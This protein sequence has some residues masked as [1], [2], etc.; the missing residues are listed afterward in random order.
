MIKIN[1]F[2]LKSSVADSVK[3]VFTIMLSMEMEP[4]TAELQTNLD[5]IKYVGAVSFAGEILGS[6]SIHLSDAFARLIT[7]GIL[8]MDLDEVQDEEDV[9]D[10]IRELSNMIGGKLKS[11]FCDSGLPCDLSI[12]S[13]TTGSN[14]KIEIPDMARHEHFA[15]CNQQH[16]A[17]VEVSVMMKELIQT[18][19]PIKSAVNQIDTFDLKKFV[20]DSIKEVFDM[21][22][23][24]EMEPCTAISRSSLDGI[25]HVGTVSFAGKVLGCIRIHVSNAFARLITAGML[26]MDLDEIQDE[27]DVHDV[28]RELSNMIGGKLKSN[29]CDSG[30]SCDL[31]IPSITTGSDFEINIPD[32]TRHER[33]AF[34]HQE[35][36]AFVEVCIKLAD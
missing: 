35:N 17:F 10:V 26:G 25:K 32:M 13:I 11:G 29:F 22:L 2:D 5:G 1:T 6:I 9:H 31:S 7:A 18:P 24:M 16:I 14:F 33:F 12:P 34:S 28:I 30:L 21:M 15:F 4:C 8:G 19:V 36:I 23:S 20:A 27:E 3:E